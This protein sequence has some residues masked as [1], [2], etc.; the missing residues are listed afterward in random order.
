MCACVTWFHI[1]AIGCRAE[2]DGQHI[3]ESRVFYFSIVW[4]FRMRCPP[5]WRAVVQLHGVVGWFLR[6]TACRECSAH[7]PP[8]LLP[9]P[10]TNYKD[11]EVDGVGHGVG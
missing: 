1:Q 9:S 8:L 2:A 5:L 3:L 10:H 11:G 7:R 6:H 4:Q